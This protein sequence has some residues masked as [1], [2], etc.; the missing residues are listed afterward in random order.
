[1]C[2]NCF[3]LIEMFTN[4]KIHYFKV[5]NSV[6]FFI[7]TELCSLQTPPQEN[8]VPHSSQSLLTLSPTRFPVN[9]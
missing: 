6:A 8:P 2:K 9:R 3:F 4:Y 5:Y 1:M 7:F